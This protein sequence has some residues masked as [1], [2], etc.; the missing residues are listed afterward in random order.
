[1]ETI[2]ASKLR[3]NLMQILKRTERG[4]APLITSRGRPVAQLT[5]P[6]KTTENALKALADLIDET[7]QLIAILTTI[8]KKTKANA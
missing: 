7:N 5:P 8:I 1:M 3:A 4:S 6:Q 2:A